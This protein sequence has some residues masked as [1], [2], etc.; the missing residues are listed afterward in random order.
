MPTDSRT[1][2]WVTPADCE[3]L[4]VQL[5]VRR[6]GVVDGQRLRVA[7]VRQV[8]EQREV[9]DERLAGVR[10]ALDA[11]GD[12]RAVAAA[13][14]AVG[15][16]LVRGCPRGP[17]TRPRRRPRGPRGGGPPPARWRCGARGAAAASRCPAGTGTR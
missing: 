11:E 13:Q 12:Q 4:G 2:S 6:R 5:R 10:A 9:L 8:A 17:G 15:D 3:L 1:V 16:R 14:R 7:D